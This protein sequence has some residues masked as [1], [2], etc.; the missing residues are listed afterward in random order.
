VIEG[1]EMLKKILRNV[2]AWKSSIEWV[3]VNTFI[4]KFPSRHIR[5]FLLRKMGVNIEKKVSMFGR[6]G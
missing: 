1:K 6:F 4:S 2:A 3:Y 5:A